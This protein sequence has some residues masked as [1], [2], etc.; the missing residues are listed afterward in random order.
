MAFWCDEMQNDMPM[1]RL[2]Y[3][4]AEQKSAGLL[5][6]RATCPYRLHAYFDLVLKD[7]A[8]HALTRLA[9]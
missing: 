8:W 4:S 3:A 7:T 9:L 5:C 2:V 6:S 1:H